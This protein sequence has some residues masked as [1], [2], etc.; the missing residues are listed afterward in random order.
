MHLRIK[1]TLILRPLLGTAAMRHLC[2]WLVLLTPVLFPSLAHA[3]L[4]TFRSEVTQNEFTANIGGDLSFPKGSGPFPVVILLHPC[5]GLDA[6]ALTT[7]RA[8]SRELLSNGFATLILDSYGPRNLMGGKACGGLGLARAF[9]YAGA[10]ALL[11]AHWPVDSDVAV[12]L[13]TTTFAAIAKNPGLN[14]AEALRLA[15]LATMDDRSNPVG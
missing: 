15:M 10:R 2:H 3:E 9:F 1:A 5:G 8:H 6:V 4:L 14:T 11:V 13:M 7:L 12:K